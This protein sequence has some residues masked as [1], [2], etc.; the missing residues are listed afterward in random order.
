MTADLPRF[1]RDLLSSCPTAGGGVHAWL[2]RC[3][4]V[5]HAFYPN[6]NELAGLLE[7]A[8]AG[9]GRDIPRREIV[10]AIRDSEPCKWQPGQPQSGY[11]AEPRWPEPMSARIAEIAK[12][13]P[14]LVDLWEMSPIRID[15]NH[16]HTEEIIDR[17]FPGNPLLCVGKTVEVFDTKPREEWRGTLASY[18]LVVPSPMSA[19]TGK[20]KDG[21]ESK[22][23]L[24]NTGPRRFLV[25]EFDQGG[26][27]QHAAALTHLASMA[28][29]A[30][31]L[32][33]GG[34]SLHG[35]FYCQGQPEQKLH[36]F[37][38]YAV[39]L[40]ADHRG[41]VRSQFMRMP[42][43]TRDNGKRQAV[44]FFNPGIIKL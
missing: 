44:Y 18:Q 37:M 11:V 34:K 35:W 41:W 21:K 24:D 28:P 32:H 42:D 10:A 23:T 9:C 6:Q 12:D 2:F 39:T 14:G 8:A 3:A 20:T 36:A 27:D 4:R 7:A 16:Q 5:L 19:I 1:V 30:L 17:L 26:S 15:D 29:L 25:V 22:H 38:R 31:V 43:G 33:S 40:G 13:G